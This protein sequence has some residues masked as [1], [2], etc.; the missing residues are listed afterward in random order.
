MIL[1]FGADGPWRFRLTRYG[2]KAA[3][4]EPL[5]SKYGA[6]SFS[7]YQTRHLV[8][9]TRRRR[10]KGTACEQTRERKWKYKWLNKLF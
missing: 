8:R 4:N 1:R 7:F 10:Q 9:L 2:N 6:K 5:T 3:I